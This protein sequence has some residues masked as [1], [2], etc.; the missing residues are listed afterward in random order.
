MHRQ[1][2]HDVLLFGYVTLVLSCL[3]PLLKDVMYLL[4]PVGCLSLTV[5]P[6]F[7]R[8]LYFVN[9]AT[10]YFTNFATP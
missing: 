8:V 5:K 3:L 6:I 2:Y 4:V 1:H 7:L 10:F 9:F